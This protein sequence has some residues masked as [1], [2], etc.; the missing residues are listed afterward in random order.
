MPN[1]DFEQFLGDLAQRIS[2]A[3]ARRSRKH[4]ARLYGTRAHDICSA[5]PERLPISAGVSARTFHEREARFLFETEWAMTAADILERRTKHGLHLTPAQRHGFRPA[6]WLGQ[7][8][9]RRPEGGVAPSPREFEALLD[10]SARVGADPLLVQGAGGNTSI[11]QDGTLWIKASGTWLWMPRRSDI[12]VPVALEPLARGAGT[13]TSPAPRRPRISSLPKSTHPGLRPS[14]ETTVHALMPQKVVI[15]V[16]CVETI[17]TGG[18]DECRG[19]RR[20]AAAPASN[21]RSCPMRG[22]DCRWRGHRRA[23]KHGQPTLLVL[24]N[25]GLVV[26][27][28]HR[29]GGRSL[30]DATCRGRLTRHATAGARGRLW[31]PAAACRR[32]RLPACPTLRELHAAAT[33]LTAAGSPP[34][35]ASIPTTSSSS[36]WVG[37]RWPA[38]EAAPSWPSKITGKS[39]GESRP[40]ILFPGKGC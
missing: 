32:Q 17:A 9:K 20:R 25:H 12:M 35:A 6:G 3:A 23:A 11:K 1:A 34:A 33:D 16:H 22:R 4:Y 2:V 14:I 31:R 38:G 30:L 26:A 5:V 19:H 28:R 7:A 37:H 18:A 36:A 39:R 29:H 15:H 40:P 10:V 8:G 13:A 24:G 21:G 27:R